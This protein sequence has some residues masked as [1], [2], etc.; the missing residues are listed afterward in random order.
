MGSLLEEPLQAHA[1]A[2]AYEDDAFRYRL[3]YHCALNDR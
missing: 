1:H 2:H 3:Q